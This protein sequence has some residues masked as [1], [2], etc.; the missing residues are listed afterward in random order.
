MRQLI[1]AFI[2][3]P[4]PLIGSLL[5]GAALT[6]IVASRLKWPDRRP[7]FPHLLGLVIAVMVPTIVATLIF[8]TLLMLGGMSEKQ[9]FFA[10]IFTLPFLLPLL[11]FCLSS[12]IGR[13]SIAR[14][15]LVT[16]VASA[17][18]ITFQ[19]FLMAGLHRARV[20]S[21][22]AVDGANL[23]GIG[24]GLLLYHYDRGEHPSD[25]RV[26]VDE[27]LIGSPAL[28]PFHSPW[29]G[30]AVDYQEGMPFG[31]PCGWT[32][33]RLA[34]DAPPETLW[35]WQTPDSHRGKGAYALTYGGQIEWRTPDELAVDLRNSEPYFDMVVKPSIRARAAGM[36]EGE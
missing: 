7:G 27:E 19:M 20:I 24:K 36:T 26:L 17:S 28:L 23:S 3:M 14:R 30:E 5:G 33:A 1:G 31:G 2:M 11:A 6:A 35:V 15:A 29:H 4:L 22:R 25:L 34:D 18:I 13:L 8:A 9:A 10:A 32:Y 12:S 21:L 16:L